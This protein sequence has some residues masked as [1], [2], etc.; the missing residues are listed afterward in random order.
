VAEGAELGVAQE[1]SDLREAEIGVPEK[2]EGQIM[3]KFV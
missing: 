3:A 1:E 2:S